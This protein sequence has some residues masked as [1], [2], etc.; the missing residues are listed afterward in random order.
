MTSP[1]LSPSEVSAL[2]RFSLKQT[3]I[4]LNKGEL[5]GAFKLGGI[6]MIDREMLMDG[7]KSKAQK[8]KPQR[9]ETAPIKSRHDL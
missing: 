4:L 9:K 5:P 2:L 1:F 8:P 6:W 7:L 3:Y